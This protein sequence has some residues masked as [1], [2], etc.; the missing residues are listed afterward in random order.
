MHS[1]W[2]YDAVAVQ[3]EVNHLLPHVRNIVLWHAFMQEERDSAN[4]VQVVI[5][6][7]D[8]SLGADE[9]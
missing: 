8:T 3:V 4:V 5:Q 2:G 6:V 9:S 1:G 7:I